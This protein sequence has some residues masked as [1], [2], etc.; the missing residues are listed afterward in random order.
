M[1]CSNVLNHKV[2]SFIES[3]SFSR[4]F[5]KIG[6]ASVSSLDCDVD[7]SSFGLDFFG[8]TIWR[9]LIG[10]LIDGQQYPCNEILKSL[11]TSQVEMMDVSE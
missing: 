2:K 8:V 11:P 10:D 9:N 7:S 1:L 4:D 5:T 6:E 3:G